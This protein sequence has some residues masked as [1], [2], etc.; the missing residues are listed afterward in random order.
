MQIGL[1]TFEIILFVQ[2]PVNNI[3]RVFETL[4]VHSECTKVHSC[5]YKNKKKILRVFESRTRKVYEM[6][7][8]KHKKTIEYVKK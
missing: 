2:K 1:D 6:F 3:F 5:L 4:K 8:Y 7:V